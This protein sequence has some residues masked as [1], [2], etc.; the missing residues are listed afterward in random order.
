VRIV[1]QLDTYPR[2]VRFGQTALGKAVLLVAFAV[3]L[4]LN[5]G[6]LYPH[7]WQEFTGAVALMTYFPA[8]RRLLLSLLSAL[9][10]LLFH[11]TWLNSD[12]LEALAKAEGQATDWTLPALVAGII[13]AIFLGFV[14]LFEFIRRVRTPSMP[15]VA[16]RPVLCLVTGYAAVLAAAALLPL[17]GMIR[18]LLWAALAVVGPYLWFFAYALK[19]ATTKTPD[20]ITLQFGALRPF[21]SGAV[22]VFTPVP[23]GAGNLRRIEARNPND[24]SIVQLKAIKLLIWTCIV[25]ASLHLL[26]V[27]V[28]GTPSHLLSTLGWGIP[29]LRVPEISVASQH[30][31]PLYLAWAS[32]IANFASRALYI[33]GT[34]HVVIACCRMAGFN[35]LRNSYR[36]L[37]SRTVAEFWNRFTYYFKELLVEF[38]FF[39]AFTRYF[40]KNIRFRIFAATIA[41]ATIGNMIYHFLKNFAWVAEVGL[42]RALMG[43]Q[44]YAF[45][46]TVL[47]LGIGISQLRNADRK[48]LG[49]DAPWWR[50]ALATGGVVSFFA[51]LGIFDQELSYHF[52]EDLR[53]F[54][55]LFLIPV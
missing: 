52:G 27:F 40:K 12:F 17:S 50:R 20:G 18:L 8:R 5:S 14:R 10:M 11:S 38:F 29:T 55:R 22:D 34:G 43:F 21:W 53:F 30:S 31:V 16:K 7:A 36:F 4:R 15:F 2:I 45:Y 54:L 39:P 23:K 9:H 3:G 51:L 32:V 48:R 6:F 1:P 25:N 49:D 46:A 41:A 26:D 24:L 42:W 44:E 28:Y 37:Y 19:D 47:G 33:T 35:A 13:A